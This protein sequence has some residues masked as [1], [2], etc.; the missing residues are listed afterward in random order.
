MQQEGKKIVGGKR[1]GGQEKIK[2]SI[3]AKCGQ[4]NNPVLNGMCRYSVV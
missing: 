3:F 1:L 4:K 2:F